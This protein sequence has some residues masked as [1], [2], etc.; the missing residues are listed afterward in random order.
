MHGDAAHHGAGP[1]R[2]DQS[3]LVIGSLLV[4]Q[5]TGAAVSKN[6]E[7]FRSS[8]SGFRMRSAAGA[9]AGLVL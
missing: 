3:A 4:N 2:H 9:A 5:F 1:V 6:D 7:H 8:T